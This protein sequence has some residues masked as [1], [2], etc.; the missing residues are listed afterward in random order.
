M[1][2]IY[3]VSFLLYAVAYYTFDSVFPEKYINN[4]DVYIS[5]TNGSP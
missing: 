4:I 2:Y 5:F 1:S 3:P